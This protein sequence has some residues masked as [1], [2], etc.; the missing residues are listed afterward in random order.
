[1][2]INFQQFPTSLATPV[3]PA[4]IAD[5]PVRANPGAYRRA[6]KRMIDVSA[7]VLA[8]PIVVPV[9]AV[10]AIF[11]AA[12]GGSPFYAQERVGRGR[13]VF[14]MWKLRSMVTDAD[15]RM[16]ACLAADPE[17]RREW[18]ETQKLKNDPR[19]TRFGR[20][21]RKCSLDELPQLWNVLKGDMS[22]VG[23]RPMMT[24]QQELYPSN[25]YYAMR[26]GIT[27]YWQTSDRN[28]TSFA[29]RATYDAA[30][31]RDLSFVTDVQILARTVRTVVNGTGY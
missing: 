11:V 26:P 12:D 1:M 29:A 5:A 30:Y 19:I 3:K 14:K 18:D 21:L 13:H 28:E 24:S 16:E 20:V 17:M 23:P 10:L 15:A 4:V 25:V 8:A 27:G 6:F 9:V 31:E 2:T 22:L 7:V